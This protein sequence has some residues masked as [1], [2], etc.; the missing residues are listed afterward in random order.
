MTSF[1]WFV[2]NMDNKWENWPLYWIFWSNFLIK[3][4]FKI[5]IKFFDTIF[6]HTS[7]KF[8]H[9]SVILA[10]KWRHFDDLFITWTIDEK[11]CP[12]WP[13]SLFKKLFK[14]TIYF[15]GTDLFSHF[16]QML[17]YSVILAPKWR[18]FDD[19]FITWTVDEKIDPYNGFFWPKC[20]LKKLSK[21]RLKFF[22]HNFFL[23]TLSK[24][25]HIASYFGPKMT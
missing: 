7:S 6:F 9:Y 12:F 25:W 3:K 16:V 4:L 20:L 15:F 10:P 18:H 22:R 17:T 21:L 2:H 23:H 14:F 13:N 1:W 24:F 8:W 19:L 11:N 5:T